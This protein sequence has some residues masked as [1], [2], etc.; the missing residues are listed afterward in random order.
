LLNYFFCGS[1]VGVVEAGVAKN[2]LGTRLVWQ[3][4][5]QCYGANIMVITLWVLTDQPLNKKCP[6]EHLLNGLA[7]SCQFNEES[8]K[9]E[10]SGSW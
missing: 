7:T 3:L 6:V 4:L 1:T 10:F 5:Y 9:P 8:W 2:G